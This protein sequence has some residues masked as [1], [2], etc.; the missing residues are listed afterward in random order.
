VVLGVVFGLLF[1]ASSVYLA[2]KVGLT[3]SASIPIAVFSIV[4]LRRLGRGSILENNL[5]QTV[6]SAGESIAAGS[7]F[8]IPAIILLGYD[9]DFPRVACIAVVG[10]LLG[11]LLM[12][13]LRRALIVKE[14]GKLKYPEG[15]ACAEVLEAG[16]KGGSQARLILNGGLLGFVYKFLSA[17]MRLWNEQPEGNLGFL[18]G[19]TLSGEVSPELLGV[20][21]IIGYRGSAVMVAGGIMSYLVLIPA[22]MI[23]GEGLDRPFHAV[24][25]IRD[26]S[27]SEVRSA[28]ILYIGAGA[29]ATGGLINLVRALPTIIGAFREGLKGLGGTASGAAAPRT[30]RDLSMRVVLAGIALVAAAIW[31]IPYFEMTWYSALLVVLF[32]FFFATVSSRIVGEIGSSNNPISGM[33]VAALLGTCLF[34]LVGGKTGIAD[35][36]VAISVGAIVCIVAANAGATSQDLKT[37][38]LV[39]STPR[40]QQIGILIGAASSA[41]LVGATS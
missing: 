4:T 32:G 19:A 31:L 20:G 30:E 27:P 40:R 39:G 28:Y 24:K 7:V 35:R 34:F 6:G 33:T 22:I 5:V 1:G 13:P 36:V 37:G 15:V 16:E 21:Y 10:G 38:F 12:I 14:H 41:L 26:M 9:L 29:V 18:K 3:V 17:G 8:V 11:V 25:L 23:F 2:L